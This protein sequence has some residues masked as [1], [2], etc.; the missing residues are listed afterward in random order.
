MKISKDYP[1]VVV[2]ANPRCGKTLE[3]MKT[4]IVGGGCLNEY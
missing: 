3:Q 2:G 4:M 1:H